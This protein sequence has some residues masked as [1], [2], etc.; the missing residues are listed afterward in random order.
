MR[1]Q[2]IAIA[3]LAMFATGLAAC[4]T[5]AAAPT[6]QQASTPATPQ[7]APAAKEPAMSTN[8]TELSLAPGKHAELAT[9]QLRYLRLVSDS[10]C[11]P[12]MQ[13]VWAGDAVIE[14]S[15]TPNTGSP[16]TFKLHSGQEPRSHALPGGTL[17]LVE[18]GRNEAPTATFRFLARP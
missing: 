17:E 1:S 3:V 12:D 5:R 8:A 16:E 2:L 4:N 10:R 15:F 7:S 11:P 9:G 6:V 14:L 18:L 13:C